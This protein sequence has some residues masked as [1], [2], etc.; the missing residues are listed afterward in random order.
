MLLAK[1]FEFKVRH[2]SIAGVIDGIAIPVGGIFIAAVLILVLK[3]VHMSD[4]TKLLCMM[5]LSDFPINIFVIA[6]FMFTTYALVSGIMSY[7]DD[8]WKDDYCLKH[9][10]DLKAI[11]DELYEERCRKMKE[12]EQWR[13]EQREKIRKNKENNHG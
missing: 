5:L 6:F 2:P 4:S 7:F 1:Y 3:Q 8:N 10:I 9:G 13:S 11:R 12:H